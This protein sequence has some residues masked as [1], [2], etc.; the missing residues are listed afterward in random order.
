FIEFMDVGTTNS[1]QNDAVVS[2]REIVERIA[3]ELP[4][5][6]VGAKYRGE[7]AKRYRYLD[8]GGEVG[9]I[10]SVTQP[11]CGDCSRARLSAEGMLYTC[12]FSQNGTDLRAKLRAGAS[13]SEIA[14]LVR[15]G[16]R[17]RND[18][19]SEIRGEMTKKLRRIEMSYIGG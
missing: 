13:D 4:L 12:L 19:Y 6:P 15:N 3:R 9:I 7:V 5:E 1:W 11:F 18:R 10:T 14:E 8:G 17:S 2:G 16:W